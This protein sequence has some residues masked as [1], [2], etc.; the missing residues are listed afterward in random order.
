MDKLEPNVVVTLTHQTG[1]VRICPIWECEMSAGELQDQAL[2][3]GLAFAVE[4][5]GGWVTVRVSDFRT[6]GERDE[7]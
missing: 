2:N 3:V 7:A 5:A 6:R 4:E 1:A